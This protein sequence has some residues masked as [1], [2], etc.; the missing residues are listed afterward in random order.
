MRALRYRLRLLEPVLVSQAGAGEENSAVGIYYIPGSVLRGALVARW[1]EKHQDVDLVADPLARKLFL[2]GTVCY[3]NA[4]PELESERSLPVPASWFVEKEQ[5]SDEGATIYDLAVAPEPNFPTKKIGGGMFCLLERQKADSPFEE[6]RFRAVLTRPERCDQVHITLEDV[7]RR[8]E[9]NQV[10]RYEALAPG[11]NFI[12]IILA[13]TGQDLS[14][15]KALLTEHDLFLG[16]AHLAG[17]GRVSVELLHDETL[18]D[19]CEVPSFSELNGRVV[20]TLLSPAILRSDNGQVGWDGGQALARSIGLPADARLLAAFG[21]TILMGGY[22]RKWGLPLPQAWALTEGSVFVFESARIDQPVLQHAI[23]CG[24]GERRVEGYGR[25]AVNWQMAAKLLQRPPL[26]LDDTVE[27]RPLSANS[28]LLACRMAQRRLRVILDQELI[29]RVIREAEE[30]QNLPSNAQ[31]SA[32]RQ[33]T[34]AGWTQASPSLKPLLDYL[35]ALKTTGRSQLDRC[36][37]GFNGPRLRDWL[38]D[39]AERLDVETQLL[40]GRSLPQIAGE[41]AKLT[42]DLRVEYTARLIDGVMQVL[43]RRNR[44]AQK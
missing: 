5:V 21:K 11:Q 7:N 24:I 1:R 12:G 10:F 23:D 31:I 16:T 25:I 34:L 44:E 42:S 8:G 35:D 27:D 20:I 32:I 38:R 4:Y 18:N 15:I 6:D 39:R 26:D 2:D 9:G 37:M 41:T 33:V 14:E 43:A 28:R 30:V 36:R 40:Q 29:K 22:N 17:Y 19:W 3:L 13:P